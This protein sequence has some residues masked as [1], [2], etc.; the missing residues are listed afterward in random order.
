MHFEEKKKTRQ[1]IFE[2]YPA[3]L[4]HKFM[5]LYEY[6]SFHWSSYT[7]KPVFPVWPELKVGSY[8]F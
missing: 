1:D 3:G 5:P 4:Y 2:E 8:V 7:P 6:Q